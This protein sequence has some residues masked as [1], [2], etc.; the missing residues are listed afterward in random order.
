MILT[1]DQSSAEP[2]YLQIRA[3]IVAA[4]ARGDLV[5][6]DALPTVRALASDL[7]INLHTVNRA[8]AVLRDEGYVV[9]HG[10]KGARIADFQTAAT[11]SQRNSRE[12]LLAEALYQLALEHRA[13]GGTAESF[14]NAARKQALR[15]FPAATAADDTTA[16]NSNTTAGNSNAAGT[17][18]FAS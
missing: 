15:A 4:I 13:Q 1:I 10:R 3:Q 7:G 16:G 11:D 17:D 14:A 8:Y 9:M 12:T 18:T 5:P 6:G 2:I